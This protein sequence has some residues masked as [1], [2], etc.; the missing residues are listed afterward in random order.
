MRTYTNDQQY[1]QQVVI[2]VGPDRCG[3]TNIINRI[4]AVTGIPKFKASNEHDIFVN[5]QSMFIDALRYSDFRTIDLLKQVG[6]SV[7]FDRQY[8]CEWVYSKFFKRFTDLEALEKLDAQFAS[9]GAKIVFCTRRSFDGIVDD[10]NPKL[11]GDNLQEI[12]RL[13]DE[14]CSTFTKCK[15]LKVFVDDED[16][17]R[18]LDEIL[19][20]ILYKAV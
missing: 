17:E 5:K 7:L 15:T 14:F 20:F 6:F 3:K 1:D 2:F 16:I 11:A 9:I 8:P 13:Y 18:E 19:P 4:S 10:L 12:S